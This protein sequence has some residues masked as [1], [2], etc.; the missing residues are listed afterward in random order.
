MPQTAYGPREG[1]REPCR[2]RQGPWTQPTR[3]SCTSPWMAREAASS[4]ARAGV[5]AIACVRSRRLARVEVEV[6]H[7]RL[8][9]QRA[10]AVVH[11]LRARVVRRRLPVHAA[12]AARAAALGAG[13][14]ERAAETRGA[15]LG[16]HV[17]IVH[18]ADL[19]RHERVEGPEQRR[20]ADR[21]SG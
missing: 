19:R 6:V 18:D 13:V 8:L 10:E 21:L 11:A 15:L 2:T 3:A 7:D 9:A 17:E 5:P 4:R 12:H 1:P 20:E 14:D 16:H